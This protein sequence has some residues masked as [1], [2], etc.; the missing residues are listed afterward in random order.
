MNHT[1]TFSRSG[2]VGDGIGV[3]G[4]VLP[5][6]LEFVMSGG[7]ISIFFTLTV[8]PV[9]VHCWVASSVIDCG[10]SPPLSTLRADTRRPPSVVSGFGR[11][12]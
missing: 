10:F 12:G 3:S 9:T 8:S 2:I 11:P 7:F 1:S 4:F 6:G 5:S